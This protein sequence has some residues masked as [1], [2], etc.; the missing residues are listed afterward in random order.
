M[1]RG[2]KER[3]FALLNRVGRMDYTEKVIFEKRLLKD[4]GE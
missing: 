4:V 3:E 2:W 1:L